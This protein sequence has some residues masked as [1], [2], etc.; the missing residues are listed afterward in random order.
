ML[1]DDLPLVPPLHQR[2]DNGVLVNDDRP[3]TVW[4]DIDLW[5]DK[6]GSFRIPAGPPPRPKRYGLPGPTGYCG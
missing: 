2:L 4:W 6:P 3:L 5:L 1:D